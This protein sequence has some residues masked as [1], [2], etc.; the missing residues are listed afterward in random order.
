M[1][2]R[3]ARPP[4]RT[5]S[6]RSCCNATRSCPPQAAPPARCGVAGAAR[7]GDAHREAHRTQEPAVSPRAATRPPRPG[8]AKRRSDP[9]S[10]QVAGRTC[11]GATSRQPRI[12]G[13]DAGQ[14]GTYD[15]G[16]QRQRGWP[17][18]T[19]CFGPLCPLA[20][21]NPLKRLGQPDRPRRAPHGA[22]M[23]PYALCVLVQ[24]DTPTAPQ[25]SVPGQGPM[26]RCGHPGVVPVNGG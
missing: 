10:T 20:P 13:R 9:T 11:V 25:A 6:P 23:H 16:R 26:A 5:R 22:Q 2:S 24:D 15:K 17:A 3:P 12:V 1:N 19:R 18:A 21:G 7:R 4:S 14:F 8:P